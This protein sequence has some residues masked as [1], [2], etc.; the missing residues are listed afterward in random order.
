[1]A[2]DEMSRMYKHIRDVESLQVKKGSQTWIEQYREPEQEYENVLWLG[3]HLL[4]T[5][6]IAREL[7]KVFEALDLDVVTVGGPQFCCGIGQYSRGDDR[8]RALA[9]GTNSFNRFAS[10]KP[11]RLLTYCASC[12]HHTEDVILGAMPPQPYS[13]IHAA[14]F[15]ASQA[16]TIR[17]K[18]PVN[19][20]VA[21]HTHY[22]GL[23][24]VQTMSA[25]VRLLNM[26]PGVQ[27]IGT[28]QDN[29][30][31]YHCDQFTIQSMGKEAFKRTRGEMLDQAR[32]MH[33][34]TVVTP[35]HSCQREWCEEGT[36]ELPIRNW[37]SILAE[38]LDCGEPDLL[39]AYKQ[40]PDVD[41]VVEQG[42]A[43]WESYGYDALQA[44]ELASRAFPEK[45]APAR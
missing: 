43:Y 22:E 42:R 16:S 23:S 9:L 29:S 28:V 25:M 32:G 12:V 5:A 24:Q 7:V 6:H 36:P 34:T 38:A 31:S 39:Q 30:M 40:S 33:A 13:I 35:Y 8:S 15:L 2:N 3:C 20:A 41:T 27:V 18:K 17:W 45:T 26:V 1:M 4:R 37:V 10:Y 11:Q 21:I 14:E 19:V 44:T